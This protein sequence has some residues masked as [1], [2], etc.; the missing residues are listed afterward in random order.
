MTQPTDHVQTAFEQ[1]C[2]RYG[3][4]SKARTFLPPLDIAMRPEDVCFDTDISDPEQFN[5]QFLESR[6]A[7]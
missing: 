3:R 4:W 2:A 7:A 6:V 5:E 1:A